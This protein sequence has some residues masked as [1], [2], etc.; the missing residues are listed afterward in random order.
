[1]SEY[2]YNP[3]RGSNLDAVGTGGGGSPTSSSDI[4][5]DSTIT[6]VTVTD[7]FNTI[8]SDI[9]AINNKAF[10]I[11]YYEIID[12]SVSTSGS[13]Q[14]T[15]TGASI[16]E[17][18]FGEAGSSVLS[19]LTLQNTPTFESPSNAGGV[20]ITA[21][22]DDF[23]NWVSSDTFTN[24]VA[25]IYSITITAGNWNNIVL[26]NVIDYVSVEPTILENMVIVNQSNIESTLGA[27]I[28]PNKS[29]FIDGIIDMGTTSITVPVGGLELKGYSFNTSA[30]V[31]TADNYTMF[32]SETPVIGSGN[33]L[34]VDFYIETSGVNSK[35]YEVY[36]AT[37]FHAIELNRI[38][39]INCT[40]LGD[41][42]NY[43]QGLELGTGRFGGSPSLTLH[44]TWVGGFR[45]STSITR[46]MSDTTTEPLFKA[47]TAFVMNSRFLTDMN[48]DLGALQPFCDFLPANFPN[49]STLEFVDVLLTRNG[50]TNAED[51]NIAPNISERDLASSWR[52]NNGIN[53]T[54][55]GGSCEVVTEIETVISAQNVPSVLSGTQTPSDLQHFDSPAN[56]QLRSLGTTPIEYSVSWDFILDGHQNAEYRIE[57]VRERAGVPTVIY[58]QTRVINN[59]QGGRDVAYFTGTRHERILQDDITY[60]QVKNI[61]GNQDCTTEL[62]SYWVINRR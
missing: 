43:R 18:Q 55:V 39:Y 23:G 49:P 7:A 57:L 59:L 46:N 37:G 20:S 32:V 19:T 4:T 40:S 33:I 54:F 17:D 9:T 21:N 25:I 34:G 24:P 61:T 35:V 53:N 41:M 28:D 52:G 3:L 58:G 11:T 15:P 60:W 12:I 16:N 47:G 2:V 42:Y 6:G 62:G 14:S 36:D 56:G 10:K 45:I 31:S 13:L 5:N 22:L 51:S 30:L 44:G 48:V 38:N 1:M 26:A 29:Y 50:V 8:D 27:V